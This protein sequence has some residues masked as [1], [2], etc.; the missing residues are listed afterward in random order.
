MFLAL[1]PLLPRTSLVPPPAVSFV[2]H[3]PLHVGTAWVL[4]VAADMLVAALEFYAAK[5][6]ALVSSWMARI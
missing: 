5:H 1:A 4:A 2:R 3:K 6:R